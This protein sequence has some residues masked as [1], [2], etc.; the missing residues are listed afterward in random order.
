MFGPPR[1]GARR[2][3][4]GTGARVPALAAAAAAV[5]FMGAANAAAQKPWASVVRRNC[6]SSAADGYMGADVVSE[7]T[8]PIVSHMSLESCQAACMVEE[9]CEARELA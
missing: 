8:N 1:P 2:S 4:H 3:R 6:F 9:E 5:S 7:R